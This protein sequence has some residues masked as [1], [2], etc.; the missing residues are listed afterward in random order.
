MAPRA[1]HALQ[2][3]LSLSHTHT[4]TYTVSRSLSLSLTHTHT[5]CLYLTHIH[6]THTR[7][8]THTVSLSHTHTQDTHT[9]S[10]NAVLAAGTHKPETDDVP[11]P[12]TLYPAPCTLHPASSPRTLHP[13]PSPYISTFPVTP[14]T[15]SGTYKP[16][17]GD[18][19]C[20][21]CKVGTYSSSTAAS[22][23]G[24]CAA[25]PAHSLSPTGSQNITNCT[26]LA[27]HSGP[28]GAAC[29]PCGPGSFKIARGDGA[30]TPCTADHYSDAPVDPEP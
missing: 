14:N 25:C 16:E 21:P 18:G 23:P 19:V 4:N 5:H 2:A 3:S 8:H 9:Q 10:H 24:T 28:D 30:C 20:T 11:A 22:S 1:P 6:N 29:V 13:A 12:C 17:A 7:S 27:G 15:K 26:C